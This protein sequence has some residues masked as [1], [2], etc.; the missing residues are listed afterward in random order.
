MST[1]CDCV[2]GLWDELLSEARE[3]VGVVLLKWH[4][5]TVKVSRDIGERSVGYR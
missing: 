4:W 2:K 3:M 1:P 5:Y